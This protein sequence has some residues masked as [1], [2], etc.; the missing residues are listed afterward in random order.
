ME[1]K[2]TRLDSEHDSPI[3]SNATQSLMAVHMIQCFFR[4]LLWNEGEGAVRESPSWGAF[5]R[6][7]HATNH[8][9]GSESIT[10]AIKLE[11]RNNIKQGRMSKSPR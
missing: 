7:F 10:Y 4:N 2:L 3:P 6:S 11:L 1:T 8:I 5:A 9:L